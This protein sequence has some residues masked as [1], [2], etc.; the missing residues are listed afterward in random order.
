MHCRYTLQGNLLIKMNSYSSRLLRK[1][2]YYFTHQNSLFFLL[3]KIRKKKSVLPS[4]YEL[5]LQ[6]PKCLNI[7]YLAKGKF[8]LGWVIITW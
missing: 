6:Y 7:K 4:M 3:K 1:P 5:F 8:Y 2:V